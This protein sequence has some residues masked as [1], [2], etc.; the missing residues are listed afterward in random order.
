MSS[1]EQYLERFIKP[2]VD[3]GPALEAFR[4]IDR[5]EFV[6]EGVEG[7]PYGPDAIPLG[8]GS[9]I[10][11]PFVVADMIRH[12]D[13][14]ED[15]VIHEVG[16]G[17]AFSAVVMSLLAREVHT[18]E[19]DPELIGLAQANLDRRRISQRSLTEAAII[20]STQTCTGS[21]SP[22]ATVAVA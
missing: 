11:S 13:I 6:P 22:R 3:E 16:T 5:A 7:D 19:R 12:L 1:R 8:P 10:S 9:S 2:F 14:Q 4:Q 17:T 20:A 18:T 15:D 21:W